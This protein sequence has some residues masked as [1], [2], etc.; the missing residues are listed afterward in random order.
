MFCIITYVGFHSSTLKIHFHPGKQAA[1][2]VSDHQQNHLPGCLEMPI[3]GLSRVGN[4]RHC[5]SAEIIQWLDCG[6]A[7]WGEN[8]KILEEVVGQGISSEQGEQ[9]ASSAWGQ[10]SCWMPLGKSQQGKRQVRGWSEGLVYSFCLA[11]K[12]SSSFPSD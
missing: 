3:I 12:Y 9:L 1:C 6:S 5:Q 11:S 7:C 2:W 8:A 10:H 4:A